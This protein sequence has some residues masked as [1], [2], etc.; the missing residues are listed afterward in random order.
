MLQTFFHTEGIKKVAFRW[1]GLAG[2]PYFS[3]TK[4]PDN[5]RVGIGD[6]NYV[7]VTMPNTPTT[8]LN[9]WGQSPK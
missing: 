6:K 2:N 7:S 4:A 5:E 1:Q 3:Y 8:L 9:Y